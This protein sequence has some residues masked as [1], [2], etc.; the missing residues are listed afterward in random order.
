MGTRYIIQ[1]LTKRFTECLEMC[2]VNGYTV[3]LNGCRLSPDCAS[4]MYGYYESVDFCNSENE[5]LD[6]ILKSNCEAARQVLEEYPTLDITGVKD[7]DK[8]IELAQTLPN[9]AKYKPMLKLSD[10]KSKASLVLLIMMRPDIEFDI[11]ECAADVFSFV[12]EIWISSATAH[13]TY[14][15]LIA[16][17]ITTREKTSNGTF[18]S[19][20]YGFFKEYHFIRCRQ[21][22]PIEFGNSQIIKLGDK[23]GPDE[24]WLGVINKCIDILEVPKETK[25]IAGKTV[26]DF[27]TFRED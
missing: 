11:R 13:D 4:I 24:E 9:G 3:D 7:L 25:R 8:V 27:L 10:I 2:K 23:E 1:S 14:Q 17:N 16:P 6:K 18:G 15:E 19:N 26:K 20:S 21:V 12:R 5:D 22:L